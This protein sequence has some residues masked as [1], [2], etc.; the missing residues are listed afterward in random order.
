MRQASKNCNMIFLMIYLKF[1]FVN[2][3]GYCYVYNSLDWWLYAQTW[4]RKKLEAPAIIDNTKSTFE[5]FGEMKERRLQ[6]NPGRK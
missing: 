5:I 4:L 1:W 2:F 6:A 3:T